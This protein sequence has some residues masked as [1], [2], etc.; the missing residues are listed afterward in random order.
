MHTHLPR[1]H[2]YDPAADAPRTAVGGRAHNPRPQVRVAG[3]ART[4]RLGPAFRLRIPTS[5]LKLARDNYGPTLCGF[6]GL[7]LRHSAF[8]TIHPTF[9]NNVRVVNN[10]VLQTKP[11][12]DGL[13]PDS[14]WNVYIADNVFSTRDDCIALKSGKD[15]SGRMVNISTEGVLIE[16][17][18]FTAGH[19]G[20]RRGRRRRLHAPL[21]IPSVVLH[22]T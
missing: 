19:G 17:N 16:R 8:W 22:T 11:G 20:G 6:R 21:C 1:R 4:A 9:S 7:S 10:S 5:G 2:G 18:H 14:C 15:W 3:L 13:D 12:T